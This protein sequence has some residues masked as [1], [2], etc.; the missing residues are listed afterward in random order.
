MVIVYK[1]QKN[2]QIRNET[3]RNLIRK[4]VEM[5]FDVSVLNHYWGTS[6][7]YELYIQEIK[8]LQDVEW[9]YNIEW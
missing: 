4:V 5:N 2:I 9:N 1:Y 8:L 7:M 3:R 6:P